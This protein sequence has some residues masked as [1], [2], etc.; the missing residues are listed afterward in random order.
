MINS[1]PSLSGSSALLVGVFYQGHAR[2]YPNR[3]VFSRLFAE[4]ISLLLCPLLQVVLVSIAMFEPQ[5]IVC[6]ILSHFRP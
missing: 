4:T 5:R 6:M 3:P 1:V 2:P